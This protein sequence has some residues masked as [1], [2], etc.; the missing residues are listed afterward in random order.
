M[1]QGPLPEVYQLVAHDGT[2]LCLEDQLSCGRKQKPL[3]TDC[4]RKTLLAAAVEEIERVEKINIPGVL[5][6][7]Q[8]ENALFVGIE[9]AP[10][11]GP[12]QAA[13]PGPFDL[14]LLQEGMVLTPGA[15]SQGG[16]SEPSPIG[17]QQPEGNG[18][19]PAQVDLQ[20][21]SQQNG[22]RCVGGD[23]DLCPAAA[24][25]LP[26]MKNTDPGCIAGMG[27]LDMSKEA[28]IFRLDQGKIEG[29]IPCA[30]VN[31]RSQGREPGKGELC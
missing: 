13:T 5:G 21:G 12:H 23:L 18:R 2:L 3:N 19:G 26:A 14:G 20:A 31:R 28:G 17:P 7:R 4:F 27:D 22:V 6:K 9:N 1:S 16:M 30:P 24:G 15:N 10:R 25:V 11:T 29:A 8:P